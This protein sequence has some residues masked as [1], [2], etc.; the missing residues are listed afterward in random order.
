MTLFVNPE[1]GWNTFM[2]QAVSLFISDTDRKDLAVYTKICIIYWLNHEHKST[3]LFYPP[4]SLPS[5]LSPLPLPQMIYVLEYNT[6]LDIYTFTHHGLYYLQCK[7][8]WQRR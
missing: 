5:I 3:L 4:P 1:A 7:Q 6:L 2:V 8:G